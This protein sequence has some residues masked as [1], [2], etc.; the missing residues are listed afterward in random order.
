[1]TTAQHSVKL[2][3]WD[4]PEFVRAYERVAA[5][6]AEA[7]IRLDQP[8]APFEI[9][10]RLRAD[11]YPDATCYC[12]RSAENSLSQR[13]RCVVARDATPARSL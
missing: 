8:G 10:R 12:E 3:P 13:A 6:L 11:G 5:A 7:G 2:I 1:M 4:D 9:Q